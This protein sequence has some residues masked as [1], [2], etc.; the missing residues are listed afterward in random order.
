[1]IRRLRSPIERRPSAA[2]M[3]IPALASACV[4]GGDKWPRP[5]ELT[6]DWLVDDAQILAVVAEPPEAVPGDIVTFS[7]LIPDPTDRL[8]AVVWLACPFT[9]DAESGLPVCALDTAGLDPATASPEELAELGVIGFEPG[10]PPT[11]LIPEDT[12]EGA[13]DPLEGLYATIQV[14]GLPSTDPT[15]T[16]LDLADLELGY[17]RLVVSEGTTRNQNPIIASIEVDG[18]A[19]TPGTR[20]V[21]DPH[22]KYT[23]ELT[24]AE[25]A[26]ETYVYVNDDGVSE[27]RV[28]EP[29]VTW[30]A[31]GGTLL[32]SLTLYPYLDVEWRA[33]P[34]GQAATVWAVIRD[35]R[36]GMG[37]IELVTASGPE[38]APR[39][40]NGDS[41]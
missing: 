37:W 29:Y 41:P 4:V 26:I 15:D 32:E 25:D 36:G 21:V 8:E 24:L 1:M 34:Y 5:S 9:D 39:V 11:W 14:I 28:E 23:F 38:A 2:W 30:Y 10:F 13:E 22:Q 18:V 17:K 40:T 19:V 3:L 33:G 16:G 35:R 6:P 12:L 27:E 7:A 20:L 31:T